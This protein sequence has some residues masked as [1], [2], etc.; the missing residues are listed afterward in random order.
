MFKIY[1]TLR[2]DLGEDFCL[3]PTRDTH[4]TCA[5]INLCSTIA[6]AYMGHSGL[7]TAQLIHGGAHAAISTIGDPTISGFGWVQTAVG[8]FYFKLASDSQQMD[9]VLIIGLS[10]LACT[11][12]EKCTDT[13]WAFHEIYDV[14]L[15]VSCVLAIVFRQTE[16][17]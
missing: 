11:I 3:S 7:A 17:K 12:R 5:G 8:I 9:S 2:S 15:A 10:L 1:P 14:A 16:K 4:L 6:L 13:W